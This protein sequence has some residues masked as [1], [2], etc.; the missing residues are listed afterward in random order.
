[1][2]DQRSPNDGDGAQQAVLAMKPNLAARLRQAGFTL[3]ELL[4]TLVIVAILGAVVMPGFKT[5]SAN[6]NLSNAAS[7]LLSA[8][9][10]ARSVALKTNQ[11][12][13]V[14]PNTG[15]DWTSGWKI[16]IDANQN[17]SYDNGTDTLI[18][19]REALAPD[20][21]LGSW[22][23]GSGDNSNNGLFAYAGDG[24]AVSAGGYYNGSVM[25]QSTYTQKKRCITMG[26]V[27]RSRLFS[28]TSATGCSAG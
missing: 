28:P 7:E 5:I 8:N 22:T 10:Q 23:G 20:I 18:V 12:T 21:V 11:R 3:V 27:G 9:M 14:Q 24:F 26:R 16:Y 6:Q 17:A 13:I 15:T 25:L 2:Q 19:T 4:V 1:L